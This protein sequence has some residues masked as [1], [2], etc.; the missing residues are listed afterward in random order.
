MSGSGHEVQPPHIAMVSLEGSSPRAEANRS[1]LA[2]QQ[3]GDRQRSGSDFS[4]LYDSCKADEMDDT[5]ISSIGWPRRREKERPSV[6]PSPLGGASPASSSPTPSVG[7]SPRAFS[8]PGPVIGR[9]LAK[10]E[11]PQI[12][13]HHRTLLGH[14]RG[15]SPTKRQDGKVFVSEEV[16]GG[17]GSGVAATLSALLRA[18]DGNDNDDTDA[19]P[20]VYE[21]GASAA[22]AASFVTTIYEGRDKPANPTA[23]SPAPRSVQIVLD[24]DAPRKRRKLSRT[25]DEVDEE[26][27]LMSPT[28]SLAVSKFTDTLDVDP[29]EDGLLSPMSITHCTKHAHTARSDAV[30]SIHSISL[31]SE[32]QLRRGLISP[33]SVTPTS[34]SLVKNGPFMGEE[35]GEH[36]SDSPLKAML[37]KMLGGSTFGA[38]ALVGL[39]PPM[40]ESITTTSDEMVE[41]PDSRTVFGKTASVSAS[42]SPPSASSIAVQSVP[43]VVPSTPGSPIERKKVPFDPVASRPILPSKAK[44]SAPPP[45]QMSLLGSPVGRSGASSATSLLQQANASSPRTSPGMPRGATFLGGLLTTTSPGGRGA[46][47]LG[48]GSP[49]LHTAPRALTPQQK[50]LRQQGGASL[51]GRPNF[52]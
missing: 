39:L 25:W 5:T 28:H 1:F 48:M 33:V 7:V 3:F 15:M 13:V 4:R 17:G 51:L 14:P 36:A 30:P 50:A 18:R 6:S 23:T 42:A 45:L 43:S 34:P 11:A 21:R 46:G 40:T 16:V 26:G 24:E 29:L 2:V 52:G 22:S 47:G 20:R 19:T 12:P 31:G 32:K 44:K 35:E 38:S 37:G 10:Q 41:W 9:T 27:I 8:P 49:L